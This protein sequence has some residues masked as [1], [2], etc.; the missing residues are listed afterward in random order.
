VTIN[1]RK[2]FCYV[3]DTFEIFSWQRRWHD[4]RNF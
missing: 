2:L 4:T 1:D 3:G